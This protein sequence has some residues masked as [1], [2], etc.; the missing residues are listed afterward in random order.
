MRG[1]LNPASHGTGDRGS[2]PLFAA[3]GHKVRSRVTMRCGR[4]VLCRQPERFAGRRD[5]GGITGDAA[6]AGAQATGTGSIRL[7]NRS[8]TPCLPG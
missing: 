7:A 4:G 6:A 1:T 3:R 5:A 8:S 2:P